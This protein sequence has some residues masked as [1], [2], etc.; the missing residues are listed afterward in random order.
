MQSIVLTT[1]LSLCLFASPL[2]ARQDPATPKTS[3]QP[4]IKPEL[5]GA[6]KNAA[7]YATRMKPLSVKE[8]KSFVGDGVDVKVISE[9]K[10]RW[11]SIEIKYGEKATLTLLHEYANTASM[12]EHLENFSNYVFVQLAE[13]KMTQSV[14]HAIR[15]IKQTNHFYSL[16]G[17]P[18]LP[19][20][21]VPFIQKMAGASRAIVFTSHDVLDANL[22]VLVGDKGRRDETAELPSFESAAK[23]K[24]RSTK[25]LAEKKL[26]PLAQL[27]TI[28][29]DEE[30]DLRDAKDVARRTICLTA[31]AIHGESPPDFDAIEFLKKHKA[32]DFVSPKEKAFLEAKGSFGEGEG[33]DDLALRSRVGIIVVA[34][35]SRRDRLSR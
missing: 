23:R 14:F 27:P 21:S 8:I 10:G 9:E 17:K 34:G 11:T 4:N 31:I 6:H 35:Q 13:E 7:L 26:T 16:I 32:W 1:A 22:Q 15:Q 20:E 2:L 12:Q 30:L 24:A 5:E 28:T 25:V 33:S 29:A 19:G 18:A 3:S